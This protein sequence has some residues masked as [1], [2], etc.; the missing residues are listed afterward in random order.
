[1]VKK[2]L[3]LKRE[4]TNITNLWKRLTSSFLGDVVNQ[5]TCV[6]KPSAKMAKAKEVSNFLDL[7]LKI[8]FIYS[9]SYEI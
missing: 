4:T 1:M 2:R 6:I 9:Q 3:Q 5:G 8:L 7:S